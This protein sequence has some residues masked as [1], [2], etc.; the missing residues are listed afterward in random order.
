M[1]TYLFG[2]FLA[3]APKPWRDSVFRG[4][5]QWRQ[6]T[7]VSGLL[8]SLGALIGLAYWYMYAMT[9]WVGRDIDAALNGRLHS[10]VSVQGVGGFAL[11]V[12][13]MHPL[14]WFLGYS[15]VEGVVRFCAGA[16]T[17]EA[18]GSLPLVVL[19]KILFSPFRRRAP[20]NVTSIGNP[21]SH[22]ASFADALGERMLLARPELRDELSFKNAGP[23]E[24]LEIGASRRKKDWD[25]P[26]VVR[27]ENTYYRLE[28]CSRRPGPRPFIYTLRRLSMGVPGRSVIVYDP[29]DAVVRN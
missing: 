5:V 8:E 28:S 3:L 9:A 1:L 14:T 26:R 23:D 12:W 6:A 11:S 16:F 7:V 29:R 13:L 21:V 17:G 20:A 15:M 4:W 10:E 2:P 24:I 22:V 25:P 27:F 19:D 18:A